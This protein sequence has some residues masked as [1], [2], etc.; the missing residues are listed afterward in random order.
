MLIVQ[1]EKLKIEK[2]TLGQYETNAYTL[3][4]TETKESLVVDAPANAS[5]IIANIKGTVPKYILLTHD[6]FDHTGVIVSLRERL[7]VPLAT[8]EYSA[9]QLKTP[10]EMLLKDGDILKLGK[11]KIG[12]IFTPG[13]TPGSLC[14][15]AG[16]I[17]LPAILFFREGPAIQKHRMILSKY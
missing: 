13:H 3:V 11:L 6:H 9:F 16:I 8:H 4:C 1:N 5:E 17:S 7:H 12:A 15:S 2:L 10:P 14:F